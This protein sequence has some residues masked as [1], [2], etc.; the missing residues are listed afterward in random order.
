LGFDVSLTT[1]LC[2]RVI[3]A[4]SKEMKIGSILAEYSKEC[5]GS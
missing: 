5:Y 1:L 3:V 2:K 4:K